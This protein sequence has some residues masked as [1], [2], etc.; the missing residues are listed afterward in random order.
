MAEETPQPAEEEAPHSLSLTL[1]PNISLSGHISFPKDAGYYYVKGPEREWAMLEQACELAADPTRTLHVRGY[2]SARQ[3]VTFPAHTH[4][5]AGIPPGAVTWAFMYTGQYAFSKPAGGMLAQPSG[6]RDRPNSISSTGRRSRIDVD[7]PSPATATVPGIESKDNVD[8]SALQWSPM[9]SKLSNLNLV[10]ELWAFCLLVGG[11]AFFDAKGEPLQV[12]AFTLVP[13]PWM[14]HFS[15]PYSPSRAAL[16]GMRALG[17]ISNVTLEALQAGGLVTFG[18]AHGAEMPGGFRLDEHNDSA[19]RIDHG[20]FVYEMRGNDPTYYSL[21]PHTARDIEA[22]DE[23][24]SYLQEKGDSE[25]ISLSA[26]LSLE[27][28]KASADQMVGE[29]SKLTLIDLARGRP[30]TMVADMG[31]S[32]LMASHKMWSEDQK[33]SAKETKEMEKLTTAADRKGVELSRKRVLLWARVFGVYLGAQPFVLAL[34]CLA[35]QS[36]EAFELLACII[37]MAAFVFSSWVPLRDTAAL[38]ISFDYSGK[39]GNSQRYLILWRRFQ[40]AQLILPVLITALYGAAFS[41]LGRTKTSILIDSLAKFGIYLMMPY[42][43]YLIRQIRAGNNQGTK[44]APCW[45]FLTSSSRIAPASVPSPPPSPPDDPPTSQSNLLETSAAAAAEQLEREAEARQAEAASEAEAAR[46]AEE[47]RKGE[48][49]KK[50]ALRCSMMSESERDLFAA[51]AAALGTTFAVTGPVVGPSRLRLSLSDE[52]ER[53]V[54]IT[55]AAT[56]LQ[57]KCRMRRARRKVAAE[58]ADRKR[59][60]THI[61]MPILLATIF[62]LISETV[63]YH[64]IA[65]QAIY[66]IWHIYSLIFLVPSFYFCFQDLTSEDRPRFSLAHG[67]FLIAVVYRLNFRMA[68]ID[69]IIWDSIHEAL[70]DLDGYFALASNTTAVAIAANTTLIDV[71]EVTLRAA[72]GPA[73]TLTPM[74]VMVIHIFLFTIVTGFGKSSLNLVASPNTCPHLLF[75]FQ[76]FDACFNYSFFNMRTIDTALDSSWIILQVVLQIYIVIRDSGTLEALL[77]KYLKNTFNLLTC[78]VATDKLKEFDPNEDPLIRLQFLARIGWQFS[79][80]DVAALI[81]TPA[82][83]TFLVWR[84]GYYSF[85]DTTILIRPCE[86]HNVWIRFA[87]LLFIKPAGTALARWWLRLKMRTT[88]LGK[89]TMHGTSR[90]AAKII[91]ERAMRKGQ[92]DIDDAVRANFD[93]KEEEMAAV[94]EEISISGLNFAVLRAKLMRKW[95]FFLAVVV[96]QLFSAFPHRNSVPTGI[97]GYFTK[98][99]QTVVAVH[100][101]VMPLSSS[102]IYVHPLV[103]KRVDPDLSTAFLLD[104]AAIEAANVTMLQTSCEVSNDDAGWRFRTGSEL[105]PDAVRDILSADIVWTNDNEEH[106]PLI[107]DARSG[108]GVDSIVARGPYW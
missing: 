107:Y 46:K 59:R 73:T 40:L 41:A 22:F 65:Q 9:D 38:A 1:Q 18:W 64:L 8:M 92:G 67:F 21:Q 35:Y 99:G 15:G 63:I 13:S 33:R 39:P 19:Q 86:L 16:E 85:Q 104:R 49:K 27:T 14:L 20:A 71:E 83:V 3:P 102:W 44:Q 88:L 81:A 48:L 105:G 101:D 97:I 74:I 103:A 31:I 77:K 82:M 53:R 30:L 75:P 4:A 11:F 69:V 72:V 90:I 45:R 61:S 91:A 42:G 26:L 84:N 98:N 50:A 17:L 96:L 24:M 57:S 55:R 58:L 52:N 23:K 37:Y 5:A 56:K 25:G 54:K 51:A 70:T 89:R 47:V 68:F 34:V 100:M 76:F 32:S 29:M 66:R 60:L 7:A 2:I 10:D 28:L 94:K 78:Q 108:R 87:I 62:A 12:N 36:E 80:A 79:I 43:I 106:W 6:L 93:Y 95:R